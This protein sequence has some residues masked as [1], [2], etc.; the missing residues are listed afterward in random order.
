MIFTHMASKSG[1]RYKRGDKKVTTIHKISRRHVE[2][3]AIKM[4]WNS[5]YV[6]IINRC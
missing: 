3:K 6:E 2:F 5:E 1:T 4:F